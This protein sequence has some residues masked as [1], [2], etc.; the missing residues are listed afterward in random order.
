[1]EG[2]RM[3]VVEDEFLIACDLRD[4]LQEAGAVVIGPCRSVRSALETLSGERE[5]H[6]AVLDINIDG[7]MVFPVADALA[8]RGVPFVFA[9]GYGPETVP[10]RFGYVTRCE[11]PVGTLAVVDALGE[12]VFRFLDP[13]SRRRR[14]MRAGLRGPS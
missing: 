13:A 8:L 9:T 2:C 1:M 3:L 6:G 12:A 5:V 10:A 7:E 14:L 11:K 4:A